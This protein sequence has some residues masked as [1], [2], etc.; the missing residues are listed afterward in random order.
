MENPIEHLDLGFVNYTQHPSNP[1]YVVYRFT[2][3]KRADSF[4]KLLQEDDIQFEEDQEQKK[5][6][7][8]TLFAVHQKHY[9]KSMKMNFKVE[10]KHKKPIIPY[11]ILRWSVVVFGLSII[12]LSILSY[13]KHMEHLQEQ[14]EIYK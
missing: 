12:L 3:H 2:D 13:C 14:T 1:N 11:R 4:R 8:Y 6:L 9:K 10:Q 5:Q 7:T